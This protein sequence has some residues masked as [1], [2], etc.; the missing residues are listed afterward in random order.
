[1]KFWRTKTEIVFLCAKQ[2]LYF[3]FWKCFSLYIFQHD[4]TIKRN[5][6][7]YSVLQIVAFQV[8]VSCLDILKLFTEK[9]TILRKKTFSAVYN[10][11]A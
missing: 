6:T 2:N 5:D 7:Q 11:V 9:V 8:N 4:S 3:N 1:M 10:V